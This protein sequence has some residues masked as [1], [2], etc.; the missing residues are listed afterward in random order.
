MALSRQYTICV[1]TDDLRKDY[2]NIN[3][4]APTFE[5]FKGLIEVLVPQVQK[6]SY[7]MFYEGKFHLFT[8]L[9]I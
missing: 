6:K 3:V 1:K 9:L 2:Y 7:S 5:I 8:F 4:F